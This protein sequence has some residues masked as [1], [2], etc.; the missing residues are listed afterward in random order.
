MFACAAVPA[1][2]C[3]L[4]AG[5]ATPTLPLADAATLQYR[6][7]KAG[8]VAA[9]M[10]LL[11]HAWLASAPALGSPPPPVEAAG[12]TFAAV[13]HG[14]RADDLAVAPPPVAV[15]WPLPGEVGGVGARQVWACWVLWAAAWGCGGGG[16]GLAGL[17]EHQEGDSGELGG[18]GPGLDEDGR[19]APAWTK[20]GVAAGCA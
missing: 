18:T 16:A 19:R 20:S 7:V 12:A 10:L 3:G 4:A 9:D 17:R 2:V 1:A 11:K 13:A 6:A 5:R 15:G 8:T 14:R